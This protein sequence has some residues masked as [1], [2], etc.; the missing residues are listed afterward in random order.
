MIDDPVYFIAAFAA[1]LV[2]G[3]LYMGSLW[4]V[5]RRLP[6]VR[7]PAFWLLGSAAF[8][9]GALLAAWYGI[10]GGRWEG[11]LACV[12]G[13]LLVRFAAT[14]I[15]RAGIRQPAVSRG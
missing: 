10:S 4:L 8:R 11:L 14:R 6:R 12:A 15:V 13:F 5:L 9:I 3:T 2:L 1:G 7:H